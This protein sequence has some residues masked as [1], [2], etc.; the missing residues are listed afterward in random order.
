[1]ACWRRRSGCGSACCCRPVCNRQ[2]K[3]HRTDLVARRLPHLA[4]VRPSQVWVYGNSFESTLVAVVVPDEKKFGAWAAGEGLPR[5]LKVRGGWVRPR[6]Q[7]CTGGVRWGGRAPRHEAAG[8]AGA[9]LP[10]LLGVDVPKIAHGTN[11]ALAGCFGPH[12]SLPAPRCPGAL[13][14]AARCRPHAGPAQGKGR[15]REA[16]GG[17]AGAESRLGFIAGTVQLMPARVLREHTCTNAFYRDLW[18]CA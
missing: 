11:H 8:L 14:R 4:P 17:G 12:L 5:D 13:Q 3:P 15:S 16:Q 6:R 2:S 7:I 18:V 10:I 1:M 9:R